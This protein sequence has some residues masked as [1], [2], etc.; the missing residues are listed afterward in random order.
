MKMVG[1][2]VPFPP[3]WDAKK[4]ELVFR[5]SGPDSE[6]EYNVQLRFHIAFNKP[7]ALAGA[8]ALAALHYLIGMVEGI[9]GGIEAECRRL[10]FIT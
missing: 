8:P 4:G 9:V 5:V 7:P 6:F 10:G 1:G 3:I 2:Y